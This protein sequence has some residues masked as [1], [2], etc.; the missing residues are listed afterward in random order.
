MSMVLLYRVGCLAASLGLYTYIHVYIY[1]HYM[2][3]NQMSRTTSKASYSL[4][5]NASLGMYFLSF[6]TKSGCKNGNRLP[7]SGT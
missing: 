1:T 7:L 5:M 4:E 2:Y 3:I 6:G